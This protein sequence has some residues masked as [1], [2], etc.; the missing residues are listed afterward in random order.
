MKLWELG[1]TLLFA[2]VT[3]KRGLRLLVWFFGWVMWERVAFVSL[4]LILLLKFVSAATY[5]LITSNS[6]KTHNNKVNEQFD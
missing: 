6:A 2:T 1:V 4:R 3:L 5:N